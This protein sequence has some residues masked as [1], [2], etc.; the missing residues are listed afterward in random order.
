MN[1]TNA[2]QNHANYNADDYDYLAAKGW[3]DEQIQARWDQEASN[4]IGPCQWQ[5]E[6]ARNKLTAVTGRR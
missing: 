4:G 2:I 1:T 3:T 5:T 6:S